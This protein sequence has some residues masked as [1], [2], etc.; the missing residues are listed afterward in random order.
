MKAYLDTNFLLDLIIEGR[1]SRNDS[2]MV[3]ETLKYDQ[4]EMVLSTQSIIDSYYVASKYEV[5]KEDIDKLFTWFL[6]HTNIRPIGWFEFKDAMRSWDIDIEDASQVALAKTE[7]CDIFITSDSKLLNKE[8]DEFLQFISPAE[9]V[10]R[11]L[12]P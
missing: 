2:L 4:S 3:F 7:R 9:F 5:I 6:N 12:E 10:N 11:I 8:S 1:P